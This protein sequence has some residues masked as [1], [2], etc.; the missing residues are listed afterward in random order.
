MPVSFKKDKSRYCRFRY[1]YGHNI[2]DYF[3][4][5]EEIKAFIRRGQLKQ[6]VS[7]S[8]LYLMQELTLSL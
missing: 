7:M 1:D 8:R 2:K 6:F 4:L 5:K 3:E